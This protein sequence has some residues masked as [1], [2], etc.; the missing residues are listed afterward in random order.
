MRKIIWWVIY[1]KKLAFRY[2]STVVRC[3]TPPSFLKGSLTNTT[4]AGLA[5]TDLIT[6]NLS[7]NIKPNHLSSGVNG[8]SGDSV[9]K[10]TEGCKAWWYDAAAHTCNTRRAAPATGQS[11]KWGDCLNVWTIKQW[12]S[13]KKSNL[14][15]IYG[16]QKNTKIVRAWIF[17]YFSDCDCITNLTLQ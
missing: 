9:A 6:S 11:A 13:M 1:S 8:S 16:P 12:E 5:V 4:S 14:R 10:A 7:T 17:A 2:D 3:C 15:A